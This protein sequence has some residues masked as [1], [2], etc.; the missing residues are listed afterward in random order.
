MYVD[1]A[2]Y[3][4][5]GKKHK[6]HLLR[7]SYRE[8]GKVKK[9]TIAS[10]CG[11]KEEEIRAM[12]L[13]LKHKS[14]LHSLASIKDL[15]P[16]QGKSYGAVVLIKKI[17]EELGIA[18]AL[19]KGTKGKLALWQVIGRVLFQG[20]RLSLIRALE[21][22]AAKELLSLEEVTAKKLYNNLSWIEKNQTG[23]EKELQKKHKV[24]T[25]LYLYDV[26]SSYLEGACNE[27]SE[28]GYNRDKKKGKKQ[29][30][31]GLLTNSKGYPVAV[32]VFKGNTSD[33]KTVP[34][35]I[36]LL[37]KEFK[38]KKL[39]LVGDRAMLTKEQIEDMP[40]AFS[41]ITAIG[42]LQVKKLIADKQLQLSLFDESLTEV[43]T[44]EKRYILRRNPIRK[45]EI[46]SVR[47]SKIEAVKSLLATKN[48]Y[49]SEHDK[50]KTEI[51]LRDLNSY[52]IKLGVNKFITFA[53]TDRIISH[54]TNQNEIDKASELDGCY[55]IT[56]D[57]PAKKLDKETIHARYKDLALVESAFRVMKQSHLE[58]RP[59][60][61]RR[62]DRTK[63][64]VF[65][66]MLA[67]MIEKKLSEYWEKSKMTVPEGLSA[68]S[69]L[70]TSIVRVAGFQINKINQPNSLCKNLLDAAKVTVPSQ[71][72]PVSTDD[73]AL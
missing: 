32:R 8:N 65:I 13:A 5:S 19:G 20:S 36:K 33:S 21:V 28:Y 23:I 49:L 34:D 9:R 53:A 6:R 47:N 61:L 68:L 54:T 4:R 67:F 58:I 31:I 46:E 64:H 44:K 62:E 43:E 72:G 11:L 12:K 26:T 50:A 41:Y 15:E 25:N 10:L 27:L 17:A 42:K 37:Q 7:E 56:T 14:E 3:I 38:V 59:V 63:A 35:Q 66:T 69:T 40:E 16:A 51:A 39:T 70:T 71:I 1:T 48:K 73:S 29:I 30:V 60:F 22:H 18:N 55:C 57:I 52:A 2:P 24:N 45:E